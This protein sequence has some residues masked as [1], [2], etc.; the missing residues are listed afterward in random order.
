MPMGSVFDRI[1]ILPTSKAPAFSG[2][3]APPAFGRPNVPVQ[4][5]PQPQPDD[6]EP[7]EPVPLTPPQGPPGSQMPGMG[8]QQP[9]TSPRPGMLPGTPGV[10]PPVQPPNLP[11][12]GI[13]P[14]GGPGGE[15][16][17]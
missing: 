4:A 13:R 3:V 9:T 8:Q 1:M 10:Q 2:A 5:Q 14:P 11:P 15:G 7:V 17:N 16:Q 12:P 6:D